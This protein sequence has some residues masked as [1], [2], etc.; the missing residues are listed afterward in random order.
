MSKNAQ[1]NDSSSEAVLSQKRS[2]NGEVFNLL[3]GHTAI[4]P[5]T[6][7]TAQG[8]N[9]SDYNTNADKT[10]AATPSNPHGTLLRN[11]NIVSLEPGATDGSIASLSLSS[12]SQ[13]VRVGLGNFGTTLDGTSQVYIKDLTGTRDN[14]S[15]P[16]AQDIQ[17][18]QVIPNV[19]S[20][21]SRS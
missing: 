5:G 9:N 4:L 17:S 20:R 11:P 2:V 18:N 14:L 6:D 3:D 19:G 16:V 13:Q 21:F 8:S 10:V 12:Q 7:A 1:L 15:M